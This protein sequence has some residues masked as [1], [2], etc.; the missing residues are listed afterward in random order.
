M[1]GKFDAYVL[2]PLTQSVQNWIVDWSTAR[3]FTVLEQL[4]FKLEKNIGI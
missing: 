4:E 3:D 2:C 1:K